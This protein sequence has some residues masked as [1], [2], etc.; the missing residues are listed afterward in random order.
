MTAIVTDLPE[1]P[2][3]PWEVHYQS[4]E[5]VGSN[6]AKFAMGSLSTMVSRNPKILIDGT[7]PYLGSRLSIAW[8][9]FSALL[10]CIVAIHLAVFGVTYLVAR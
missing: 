7:V 2:S 4:R 6:M 3:S 5:K 10:A 9:S 8:G 1:S